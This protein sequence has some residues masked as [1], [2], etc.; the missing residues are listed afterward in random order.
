[1][2]I[3]KI[4]PV[5][6]LGGQENTLSLARSF[7]KLKVPVRISSRQSCWANKSRFVGQSFPLPS[8]DDPKAFWRELLLSGRYPQLKGSM[9]FACNDDAL[10]F[11]IETRTELENDYLLDDFQ[12]A[13][14][15]AM[16]DKQKTLEYAESVGVA[17][18]QHWHVNSLDDIHKIE[19]EVVFPVIIKPIHSHIFQKAY[20]G[21]KFFLCEDLGA[22]IKQ[23]SVAL[24]D[25]IE[26]MIA[27]MIPGPD[28]QLSS[29]Y[30]Y[31]DRDGNHLFHFTKRV[32]RR[33][34]LNHGAGSYHITEWLPETAE[35]GQKFF[36]GINYSGFGN[37]EFKRDL[38]DGKL[39]VIE[40]NPRYT[41]AQELVTRSG[42]DMAVIVYRHLIGEKVGETR[43]F[44][45]F[46][47]LWNPRLDYAAY[48]QLRNM[49]RLSF[50]EWL[51][52]VAHRQVFPYFSLSDPMP[53]L[54]KN[55]D[56]QKHRFGRTD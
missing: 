23:A 3:S 41:A 34:P 10:E 50:G 51:K 13:L 48:K 39:K 52:S 31:M 53:S 4:V 49:G 46:V 28:D 44:N 56:E 11:M 19:N 2:Q 43:D 1:M 25:G 7:G 37:I 38:R 36:D 54:A 47:R 9:I 22:L 30:T 24:D 32:L 40:C 20:D 12:P 29:Y 27:E 8:G 26:F 42:L 33:F 35:E 14:L 16:L 45:D 15:S 55:W 21:K 5:L 17:I 18:P 6:M